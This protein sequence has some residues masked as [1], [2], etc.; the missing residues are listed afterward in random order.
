MT[1]TSTDR[2][3]RVETALGELTLERKVRLL[4]GAAMFGLHSEPAIGLDELRLSDGPTG[5]R[6]AEFTGGRISCL[7]PNATLLAQHWDPAVTREAGE[8][9]AEE[10]LAQGVH[11]VL[12]PTINLHRTPLG[13]RVFEAFSEDPLL[14]GALT[15]TYV[16]GLQNSGVGATPKHFLANESE[17][18]RTT[19]DSVVDDRTLREVYL[20]PFE[21]AVHDATPWSIMA[22]YNRINGI[23]AT[24]HTPLLEGVLKGEWGYDGLVVSDWF[25]TS[26]TAASANGGLDL[27]MPGPGGPWEHHLLGAV[28]AGEVAESTVDD[29]VRRLLRLADRVGA[30][31]SAPATPVTTPAPDSA[32]RREQLHH[33]AAG[34]MVVLTNSGALPLAGTESVAVIGRHAVE[35]IAQGGGS[36]QV[37]PP[38]EV[39]VAEGLTETVGADRVHVVDGVEVRER[40]GAAPL[41][42]LVDPTSGMPGMRVTTRDSS[43][44]TLESRHVEHT[45]I[46]TG[47]GGWTDGAATIELTAA[48]PLSETTTTEVGVRGVAEWTVDVGARREHVR[49]ESAADDP[50]VGVI[51]PPAWTTEAE[52]APH[53]TV[54]ATVHRPAGQCVLG[55]TARPAPRPASEVIASATR[56]AREADVAVVVVGLTQ[57]QETES[58]D[59]STLALP[60][61][62]DAMV[63]AVATEAPR[64][65]VVV[66]AATP[67]LM[68]WLDQV[69]AVLWAGLPG[70]ETGAAVAAALTG[71]SEPAGRLVTTFPARDGDGPAWSTVPVDGRLTYE[72]GTAVGYRG[73]DRV[74]SPHP[75]FWFGHGLGYTTWEYG[76]AEL[77]ESDE[78]VRAVTV[79]LRNSGSRAGTET[80]QAYLRPDTDTDPVRLVGWTRARLRPGE[81]RQVR[82][83][84]ESW[85]QRRWDTVEQRWRPLTGGTV[86]VARG[87][88]DVRATLHRH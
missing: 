53:D 14:T 62:Q 74:G 29:H 76:D 42:A 64:T 9:L 79:E 46:I 3:S 5:V 40:P 69:D 55:L 61:E 30:L 7:L 34:G 87:L 26:A 16:G 47:L 81:T 4:T 19:V 56:A 59:K 6:G 52:L 38:H 77:S 20:L 50:G 2:E 63:A 68:P 72:E 11:V 23:A 78:V 15:T 65:V 27:V 73:W 24:E 21:M 10:A 75:L 57:E 66:N 17:L 45:E 43:G 82:V 41:D 85:T 84:C 12:G 32:Q 28:S 22:S 18:H 37:R 48:V 51:D 54:T 36:A 44:A 71:D 8:L 1:T 83:P 60:G 49:T 58:V 88:G 86:L 33:L 31:G 25:A 70:Q 13:G 39:S 80:V 35:P 67:V